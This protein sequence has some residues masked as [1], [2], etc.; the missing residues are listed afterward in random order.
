MC[1]LIRSLVSF[2]AMIFSPGFLSS[3]RSR[4]SRYFFFFFCVAFDSDWSYTPTSSGLR[5]HC[6]HVFL[7]CWRCDFSWFYF[8]FVFIWVLGPRGAD[9]ETLETR[10][11][12]TGLAAILCVRV[13]RDVASWVRWAWAPRRSSRTSSVG[14]QPRS[15]NVFCF[16]I[17]LCH[18]STSAPCSSGFLHQ[19]HFLYVLLLL[20]LGVGW[21]LGDL[22]RT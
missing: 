5:S 8:F 19:P 16:V 18:S 17:R 11:P 3:W 2:G 14:L 7:W 9:E 10:S 1:G 22:S 21:V 15:S 12:A 6:S 13:N 4:F 20:L